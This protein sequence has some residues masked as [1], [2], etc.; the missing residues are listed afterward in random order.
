[1]IKVNKVELEKGRFDDLQQ[2]LSATPR[3]TLTQVVEAKIAMAQAE[4][5]NWA[6]KEPERYLSAFDITDKSKAL[7]G[8]A[9][10]WEI[11]RNKLRE[12]T[13]ANSF[14]LVQLETKYA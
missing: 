11:F 5:I 8:E 2:W 3:L 9:A 13:E 6:M 14:Q 7:L 1:M 10:Q 12:L 4:A